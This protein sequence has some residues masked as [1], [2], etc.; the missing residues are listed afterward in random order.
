MAY[1]P[2]WVSLGWALVLLVIVFS[3]M[4]SPPDSGVA[5]G[6][7]IGHLLAYLGLMAWW[8]Q[9]RARPGLLLILFLVMGAVL[10][11]LQGLTP[12]R[13]PSLQDMAANGAGALLGWLATRRWPHWLPALEARLAARTGP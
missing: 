7:K 2:Y 10:E 12:A 5:Q 9:L 6:D 1:R 3:L 8:G 11:G 13:E 4:P